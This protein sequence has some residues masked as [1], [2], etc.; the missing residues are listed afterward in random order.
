MDWIHGTNC[1]YKKNIQ[2][3]YDFVVMGLSSV[4]EL[5]VSSQETSNKKVK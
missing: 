5:I 3:K 2:S 1:N 4:R